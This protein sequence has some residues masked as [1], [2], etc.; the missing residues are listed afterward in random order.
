MNEQMSIFDAIR[1]RRDLGIARAQQKAE[2]ECGDDWTRKTA[3]YLRDYARRT[4][5]Q[6]FML[7]DA[8]KASI[9]HVPVPTNA[10]AWGP[11]A[12]RAAR[13][14]WIRKVGYA[15][16]RSSNLSPKVL[17]RAG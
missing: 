10:K 2:R 7:E 15:S 9:G 6:P 1:D 13:E 16:A 17:W 8:R 5:G 14:K 3:E 11:A 12:Q 4:S